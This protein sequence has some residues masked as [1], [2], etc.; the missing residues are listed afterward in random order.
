MALQTGIKA[1]S[2][3]LKSKSSEGLA[4]ISPLDNAGKKNVVLLF[5]PLAFT[6]VCADE[7]CSVRDQ[8]KEYEKLDAEVY[9]ISVDSPF[10]QEVFAQ[11]KKLNFPLLSDFNREVS[12]QYDVLF[13]DLLG[14]KGVSKRAAFVIN[15]EG[16]IVYA[17]DSNDPK[18][19]PDFEA[20]KK[21][22]AED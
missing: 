5:F 17:T 12:K 14:F 18:Q 16:V 3:T 2:F 15:K 4:D 13:E 9:A 8:L 1:P 20:M 7:M 10:T 6:S 19:L 21:V 22:L 11:Q